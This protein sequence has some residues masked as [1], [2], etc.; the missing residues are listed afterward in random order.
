METLRLFRR[1]PA[2]LDLCSA[3][4]LSFFGDTLV[5][6]TLIL[7]LAGSD[8]SEAWVG[9]L[10]AAQTVPR[11][12]GPLFGSLVDLVEQRRLMIASGAA[13]VLVFVA[14]LSLPG[15]RLLVT[16]LVAA[17][18]VFST[19][20][21]ISGRSVLPAV[22]VHA[23]LPQANALLG[24]GLNG[25]LAFGPAAA[26]LLF[27]RLGVRGLLVLAIAVFLLA[28]LLT[29]RLPGLP[30]SLEIVAVRAGFVTA[31]RAGFRF[32][33]RHSVARAVA[34]GLF[35]TVVFAALENVA[36]VFLVQDTL[37]ATPAL[38]GLVSSAFGVGMVLAPALLL[39]RI[40]RV[41]PRAVLLGGTALLGGGM[42]LTGLAPAASLAIFTHGL[43]GMGNGLQ[44]LAN[45]TL[46]QQSV[47]RPLLGRM[48]G[49]VYSGAHL[50]AAIAY[51]AGGP[52]LA[53]TSPRIV[54]VS[55]GVAVL[56]MTLVIHLLLPSRPVE[57]PAQRLDQPFFRKAEEEAPA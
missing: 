39:G 37:G 15:D 29:A 13:K 49:S 26:G 20:L 6:T 19:L 55:A 30:P 4:L 57:L 5:T 17:A 3:R 10:L 40:E 32:L 52:F 11:L 25:S 42:S 43:S 47:P 50:A 31:T 21:S 2:F 14:L 41:S 8:G 51:L 44:N 38:Y 16:L 53:L 54:F 48:F 23:D 7:S 45:D 46:I 35:L 9:L 56:A 36:L 1:N 24:L 22:V 28:I 12:L 18:T 27:E 34:L 33:S